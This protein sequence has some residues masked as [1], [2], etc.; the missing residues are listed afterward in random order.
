M[1]LVAIVFGLS[2]GIPLTPDARLTAFDLGALLLFSLYF[3]L[4]SNDPSIRR[5]MLLFLVY[6]VVSFFSTAINGVPLLNFARRVGGTLLLVLDFCGVYAFFLTATVRSICLF[7][8]CMMLGM[9]AYLI[10][11]PDLRVREEPIKFLLATPIGVLIGGLFALSRLPRLPSK[12][13]ITLLSLVTAWIFFLHGA[14]NGGGVIVASLA[15][16]WFNYPIRKLKQLNRRPFRLGLYAALFGAAGY[17]LI[18][19]YTYAA[20]QGYFGERAASVVRF[21]QQ[22]FGSILLGGRPE[23]YVNLVAL[24]ESPLIGWGPLAEDLYHRK[25]LLDLGV[26]NEYWF[27]QDSPL[28]HSMIFGSGH[29]AGAGAMLLWLLLLYWCIKA[30]IALLTVQNRLRYFS[31]LLLASVWS[32]L[33]SPLISTGRPLLAVGAAFALMLIKATNRIAVAD[34]PTRGASTLLPAEVK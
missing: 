13:M 18:T 10:Y 1:F 17:G 22:F 4:L 7:I 5:L 28:Y 31:V 23:I 34:E 26:Y 2:A 3:R 16:V 12:I 11:P 20:L 8:V 32:L 25:M 15:F 29:E 27:Q 30:S 33:F 24:S 9:F 21:Q 19:L 14:R 6:V